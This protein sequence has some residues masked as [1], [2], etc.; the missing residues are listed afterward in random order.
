MK[1]TPFIHL[2]YTYINIFKEEKLFYFKYL[3]II[4]YTFTFKCIYFLYVSLC[5]FAFHKRI[6]RN[7]AS[8]VN[9]NVYIIFLFTFEFIVYVKTASVT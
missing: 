7:N 6:Y 2:K 5:F 4:T 9:L 1:T 8:Q 3:N